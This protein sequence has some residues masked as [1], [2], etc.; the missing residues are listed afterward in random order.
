MGIAELQAF[1]QV[2]ILH[3]K[4]I[5]NMALDITEKDIKANRVAFN[6]KTS[7]KEFMAIF[8]RSLDLCLR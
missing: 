3:S 6:K 4:N 7:S 1:K 8:Y 2:E 5:L